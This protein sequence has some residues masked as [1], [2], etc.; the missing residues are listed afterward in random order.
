MTVNSFRS[1]KLHFS[2]KFVLPWKRGVGGVDSCMHVFAVFGRRGYVYMRKARNMDGAGR[3]LIEKSY[4]HERIPEFIY[5]LTAVEG[6]YRVSPM[7]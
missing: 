2:K 4:T 7:S 1:S 6:F 3:K 5:S